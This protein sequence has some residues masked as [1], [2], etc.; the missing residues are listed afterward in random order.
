MKSRIVLAMLLFLVPLSFCAAWARELSLDAAQAAV[1]RP[2][3]SSKEMRLLVKFILP[4]ALAGRSVDFACVSLDASSV[5]TKGTVSVEAFR[6]TTAWDASSVNWTGPW[7]NAGGDWDG[8]ASADWVVAENGDK[9]VYLDVT[10]FVNVWLKEPSEN[11]GIIVKVTGP[12]PGTF[13]VDAATKPKL[14]ILH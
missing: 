8:D 1:I 10:D 12:F 13:A 3:V 5:A 7:A 2:S 11:F 6:V 9:T 4:A 14:R